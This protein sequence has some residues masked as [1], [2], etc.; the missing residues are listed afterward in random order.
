MGAFPNAEQCKID[1][2]EIKAD[3]FNIKNKTLHDMIDFSLAVL[4]SDFNLYSESFGSPKIFKQKGPECNLNRELAGLSVR[5]LKVSSADASKLLSED[6]KSAN[7]PILKR[8]NSS[9]TTI[10]KLVYVPQELSTA[11]DQKAGY[12]YMGL[13]NDTLLFEKKIDKDTVLLKSDKTTQSFYL[14]KKNL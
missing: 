8:L 7:D 4:D 11:Q 2:E 10:V 6:S 3:W 14:I 12:F 9:T 5:L 1:M 13:N